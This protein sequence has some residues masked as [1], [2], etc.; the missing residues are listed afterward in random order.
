MSA[1]PPLRRHP[2][3]WWLGWVLVLGAGCSSLPPA[4]PVGGDVWSGRLSV[5]VDA[6]ADVPARGLS[7]AFELRGDAQAG[8]IDL[9]S[10]MGSILARATWSPGAA[11][12]TTPDRQ[13]LFPDL[14]ALTREWLGQS[15]PVAAL[16]DWLHG[17]PWPQAPSRVTAQ[18]FEQIDWQVDLARHREGAISARR[19]SV[20]AV[21]MQVR[22]D[23]P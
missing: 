4:A 23:P 10:P 11:T 14:D 17:R 8:R 9:T 21:S 19:A 7:A 6:V 20:P 5:R 13:A 1:A 16:F 18:G 22:L 15:V 12:L 3:A 2:S